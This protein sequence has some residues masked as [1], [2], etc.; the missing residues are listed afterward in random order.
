MV[1]END[2]SGLGCAVTS[3]IRNVISFGKAVMSNTL[4]PSVAMD[5]VNPS[6]TTL[7]ESEV[8]GITE[9]IGNTIAAIR[10]S[11]GRFNVGGEAA[12][13]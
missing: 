9:S 7:S 10:S 1:D 3:P 11:L 8:R 6:N 4:D 5:L 12:Y 2:T 13:T